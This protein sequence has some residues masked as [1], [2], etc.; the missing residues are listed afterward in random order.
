MSLS[1][2]IINL[3]LTVMNLYKQY[4]L[5]NKIHKYKA[6]INSH[7]NKV[8]FYQIQTWTVWKLKQFLLIINKILNSKVIN[9]K[10]INKKIIKLSIKT[11][12][13]LNNKHS[14]EQ[15]NKPK[16]QKI[17][18]NKQ[19]NKLKMTEKAEIKNKTIN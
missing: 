12:H 14:V 1:L 19:E 9:N 8:C 7:D 6:K 16:K 4:Q 15:S 11:N 10:I 18:H 17:W 2:I 3:S 13:N 5:V